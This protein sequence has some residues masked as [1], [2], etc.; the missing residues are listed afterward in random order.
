M[1]NNINSV[2]SEYMQQG[3]VLLRMNQVIPINAKEVKPENGRLILASGIH[4]G[5]AH[6]INLS[7][8]PEAKL[9]TTEG[10]PLMDESKNLFLLVEKTVQLTHEEH[11]AIEVK[12]GI[13]SI[14]KVREVDP[15]TDEIR[16]VQD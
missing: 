11:G 9:F 10:I 7:E 8:L 5:H 13:Y 3:D 4:T 6:A 1:E 16:S 14:G 15:Y 2:G 12:P